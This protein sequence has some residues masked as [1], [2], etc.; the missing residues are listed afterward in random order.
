MAEDAAAPGV[1][2]ADVD[3]AVAADVPCRKC[4]YN[5]RGLPAAGRCPECGSAVGLSVHGDLLRFSDPAWVLKLRRGAKFIVY[6]VATIFLGLI[7]TVVLA[8]VLAELAPQVVPILMSVFA[9]AGYGLILGG[10][11]QLT[12]PDP[13]GLGEKEYG[14]ARK[15]IRAALVIG[16]INLLMSL[17][18]SVAV[19]PPPVRVAFQII[20]FAAG[21]AAVVGFVAQLHY[22]RK[23]S[24]R[25]PDPVLADRAQSLKYG[26]GITHG[27]L[28]LLTVMVSIADGPGAGAVQVLG[29]L[30]GVIGL[31][32]LVLFLVYLRL[33]ERLSAR[34]RDEAVVAEQTW[35]SAEAVARGWPSDPPAAPPVP[36]A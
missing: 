22:L 13:S 7:L 32:L 26:I 5:L 27:M 12:E 10:T 6:G 9:I 25:I 8:F 15:I 16:I 28:L 11:W 17:V 4:G 21:I 20:S 29:C 14:T 33:L 36:Q 3:S 1:P 2:N 23:L 35:A 18:P 19:L 24:L 34:F 30:S 31:V